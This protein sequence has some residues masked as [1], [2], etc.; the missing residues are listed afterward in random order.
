MKKIQLVFLCVLII[1]LFS[2]Q[3]QEKSSIKVALILDTSNS[4]DG[5]I[6]QA[7]SQLWSVVNELAKARCD[8]Q[9]PDLEIALYEYGNDQL[10]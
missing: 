5:L 2:F 9:I 10:S 7:K 3:V 1:P 8:G 6:D 4:M